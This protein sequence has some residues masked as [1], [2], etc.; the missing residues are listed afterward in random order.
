MYAPGIG[1]Y[2]CVDN[3]LKAHA[4]VYH[5]YQ[6]KYK[7]SF[8]GKIG[9]TLSSRFFYANKDEDDSDIVDRAMQYQVQ[10]LFI[11]FCAN[12]FDCF[13]VRMVGPSYI[14]KW[15]KLSS[16]YDRKYCK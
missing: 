6:Q 12:K 5:L 2:L 16:C 10:N 4:S 1:E 9:I 8:G 13:I 14:W 3:V 7:N 15:W 11:N